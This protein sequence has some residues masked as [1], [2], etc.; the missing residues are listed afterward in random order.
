MKGSGKNRISAGL[1]LFRRTGPEPEVFLAHPGGPFFA[2]KDNGHWTI[3]KG[4]PGGETDLLLTARREFAEETGFEPAGPFIPLGSIQQKGGKVVYAWASEG[5]P[6]SGHVH[7]CNTFQCEWPIGSGK[8]Q[9]FPE[10][11]KVCFFTI[12]EA[13]QKLKEAQVPLLDRLLEHLRSLPSAASSAYA[14]K[15]NSPGPAAPPLQTPGSYPP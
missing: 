15:T 2:R 1:L 14:P 9:A 8:F 11:D 5:E 3:P 4:E 6:P 12:S 7:C 10:I 13:R